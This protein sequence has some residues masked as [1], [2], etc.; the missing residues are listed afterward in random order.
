[1]DIGINCLIEKL[2]TD[3]TDTKIHRD[4]GS[5]FGFAHYAPFI[6]GNSNGEV[7]GEYRKV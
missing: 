5:F 1:M 7:Y 4:D 2:G 3:T 6:V